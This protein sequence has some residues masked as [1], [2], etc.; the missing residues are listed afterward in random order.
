MEL[1]CKGSELY[2]QG[3]A[4]FNYKLWIYSMIEDVVMTSKKGIIKYQD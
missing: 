4:A 1:D 3:K 2:L